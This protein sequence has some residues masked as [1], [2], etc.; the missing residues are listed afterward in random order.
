MRKA[1]R[2]KNVEVAEHQRYLHHVVSGHQHR[3]FLL[4]TVGASLTPNLGPLDPGDLSGRAWVEGEDAGKQDRFGQLLADGLMGH[5]PHV[6]QS[7]CGGQV[8]GEKTRRGAPVTKPRSVQRLTRLRRLLI[9]KR[10]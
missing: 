3:L 5:L 6:H 9:M 7:F 2:W 1:A 10:Y 8:W 4:Q